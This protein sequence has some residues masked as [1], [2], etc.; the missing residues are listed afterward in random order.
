MPPFPPLYLLRHGQTDW[1]R[2]GRVQGQMESDLTDLGRAQAARQ[3]EILKALDL[4]PG[5]AA[6]A[7]PLRRTRQTADIALGAAGLVPRFDARLKEVHLGRWEGQLYADLARAEPAVFDGN[8]VLR[9][10]L[11]GPGEGADT[12]R[13][14][15]AAF[16]DDLTGP[17]VVVSHGV[18]LS[19]LRGIVLNAGMDE[20]EAMSRDQGV[21]W[22]LRDGREITH[23]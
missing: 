17:A 5:I 14:R 8:S 16:L 7:S 22:E 15:I 20:M 11:S 19:V 2:D 10:C 18:A 4:P 21:V 6:C 12:L 3:G 13:A 23:R 9:I 1:N